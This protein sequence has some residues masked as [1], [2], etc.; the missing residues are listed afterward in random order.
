MV[1][2]AADNLPG[3]GGGVPMS[4]APLKVYL[5]AGFLDPPSPDVMAVRVGPYHVIDKLG[6]GGQAVVF[7]GWDP[8]PEK[9]RE[10]AIKVLKPESAASDLARSQFLK[11]ARYLQRADCPQVVPVWDVDGERRYPYLVMPL[12]TGGSLAERL[13][14]G[15]PLPN[16]QILSIAL[17][18]ATGLAWAHDR[19]LIHRDLSP[20]NI[21]FDAEGRAHL[22]DFQMARD[23]GRVHTGDDPRVRVRGGT[24]P[25]MSP[26]AA[27]RE[28]ESHYRD[29]YSFGAVLYHA[30][31]GRPPYGSTTPEDLLDEMATP[32]PCITQLNPDADP[33]LIAVVE[34]SMQDPGGGDCYPLMSAMLDDL[35]RIEAGELPRE[36]SDERPVRAGAHRR[37]RGPAMG[38]AVVA[39]ICATSALVWLTWFQNRGKATFTV[40]GTV[41]SPLVTDWQRARLGDWDADGHLDTYVVSEGWLRVFDTRGNQLFSRQMHR[42]ERLHVALSMVEDFDGDGRDEAVVGWSEPDRMVLEVVTQS[43]FAASRY[44][45]RGS[46]IDDDAGNLHA[47]TLEALSLT[48]LDGDGTREL[49]AR[50]VA[51][52]QRR[53]R[54]LV[55]FEIG[56]QTPR[57]FFETAG[58]IQAI[59]C[60]DIGGDGRHEVLIGTHAPANGVTLPDGTKDSNSALICVDAE[61]QPRWRRQL[62]TQFSAVRPLLMDVD[63]DGRDEVFASVQAANDYR[64][65]EA[66]RLLSLSADGDVTATYELG[67]ELVDAMAVHPY[68]ET[69]A[70][71]IATDRRGHAHLLTPELSLIRRAKVVESD[72]SN[73]RLRLIDVA[74]LDRDG[75]PEIVLFSSERR[76]TGMLDVSGEGNMTNL[77]NNRVIVLDREMNTQGSHQLAEQWK[78]PQNAAVFVVNTDLDPRLEVVTLADR[79]TFLAWSP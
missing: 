3:G 33:G 50:S 24:V 2:P 53:P 57:W 58:S 8:R 63:A 19:D 7:R 46:V 1:E 23:M 48:D 17:D 69:E 38:L 14:G 32:P 66:G 56:R 41:D 74:D 15:H 59:A 11:A 61:G 12:M 73:I 72:T 4:D 62:D 27:R 47:T 44:E 60:G 25:Y 64:G 67:S 9:Q 79:V 75:S 31:T 78:P 34:R 49:L 10:V 6:E 52:W 45:A 18:T 30:L 13:K 29:I 65:A 5:D 37:R 28:G 21:V 70:R 26:R 36:L 54:G 68:G 77:L 35:R 71:L 40:E 55:C 16:D 51:G 22:L 20:G 42:P 43:Q 76:V 39:V